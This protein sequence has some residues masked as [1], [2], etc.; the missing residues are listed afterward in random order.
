MELENILT[1]KEL[2]R[3]KKIGEIATEL[4]ISMQGSG[5]R[6]D[7]NLEAQ[8]IMMLLVDEDA[9]ELIRD[10]INDKFV[11]YIDKKTGKGEQ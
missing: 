11:V 9:D 5:S 3:I 1:K 6:N 7:L 10:I 2:E 4:K 8:G